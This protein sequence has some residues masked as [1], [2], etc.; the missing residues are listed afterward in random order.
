MSWHIKMQ[1]VNIYEYCLTHTKTQTTS[2]CFTGVFKWYYFLSR[3]LYQEADVAKYLY[4]STVLKYKYGVNAR[5]YFFPIRGHFCTFYPVFS[6]F[7][8][9]FIRNQQILLFQYRSGSRV[10]L[11]ESGIVAPLRPLL[12][13]N[14][15]S[16]IVTHGVSVKLKE[17][18][19]IRIQVIQIFN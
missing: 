15:T 3:V 1:L 8:F 16:A 5:L 11:T 10:H 19:K 18:L 17:S 4:S 12:W 9:T 2:W 13:K 14:S 6:F 7:L